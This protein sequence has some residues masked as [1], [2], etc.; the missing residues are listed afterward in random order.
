MQTCRATRAGWSP[1]SRPTVN[2]ESEVGEEALLHGDDGSPTPEQHLGLPTM[3][4]VAL[5]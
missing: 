2:G 4:N 5:N 3:T 1:V